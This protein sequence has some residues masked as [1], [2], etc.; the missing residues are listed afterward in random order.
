LMVIVGWP[1]IVCS[2]PRNNNIS[3]WKLAFI[4]WILGCPESPI[5]CISSRAHSHGNHL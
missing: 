1:D 3:L 4:Y 2:I 5:N